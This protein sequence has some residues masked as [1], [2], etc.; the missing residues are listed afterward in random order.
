MQPLAICCAPTLDQVMK[1]KYKHTNIIARDWDALA[2]FYEEVFG[3]VRVPPER[4][5]SGEWLEKGTGVLGAQV[6]GVHLR[7]PGYGDTGP[8]LEIFQYSENAPKPQPMANREGF[9][10][11]AFE[12][13]DVA[14]AAAHALR[15]G[16]KKIG[17]ITY[18]SVEGVG[19][20][21]F[22]YLADPEGNIIELQAWR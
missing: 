12:V 16:G 11:I 1:A 15:R 21:T 13:E 19:T 18:S 20:L 8:T 14:E 5:L 22:V 3:C 7:L 2:V 4:C 6:S 10:H 9:T 17:E